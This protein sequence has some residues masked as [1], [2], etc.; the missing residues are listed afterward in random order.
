MEYIDNTMES[1][2]KSTRISEFSKVVK[3]KAVYKNQWYF[4]MPAM[5]NQKVRTFKIIPFTIASKK[6][7]MLRDKSDKRYARLVQ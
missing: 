6:Q 2:E 7:E 1:T 4:Y 3:S 5:T